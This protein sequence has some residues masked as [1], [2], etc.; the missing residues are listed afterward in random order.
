MNK[1]YNAEFQGLSGVLYIGRSFDSVKYG[2][3][4]WSWA[5]NSTKEPF[6]HCGAK[7]WF[8]SHEKAQSSAIKFGVVINDE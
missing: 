7:Q 3:N 1:K 4:K 6:L 2:G 8:D 5:F